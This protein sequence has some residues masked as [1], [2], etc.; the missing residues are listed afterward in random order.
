MTEPTEAQIKYW[1]QCY[2]TPVDFLR[3][4]EDSILPM[5][6]HRKITLDTCAEPWNARCREFIAPPG[7]MECA[8]MVGIDGLKTPWAT[9]G[10]AWCNPG[11]SGLW[12]WMRQARAQ[13][14]AGQLSLVLTHAAHASNWAQW[15]IKHAA[16]CILVN[17]RINFDEDP[18]L[19]SHLAEQG[20]SPSGNNRDSMLWVFDPTY[21]GP[22]QFINPEPWR[23]A[24]AKKAA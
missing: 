15:T 17:P 7:T 24:G 11:F 22:C 21:A 19:I 18:R 4:V 1:K 10:A 8:G 5:F 23:C 6:G 2:G 13:A 3:W 20:K 16:A 12:P 9:S 14:D